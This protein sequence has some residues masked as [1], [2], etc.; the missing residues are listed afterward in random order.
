[1]SGNVGSARR[2]EYAAI[3]DT[4]NTAARLE[5]MTKGTPY[6][7]FVGRPDA[8]AAAPRRRTTSSRVDELEVRGR[9][10]AVKVW[11]L[12]PAATVPEEVHAASPTPPLREHR[13]RR[14]VRRSSPRRPT[15][16]P[17]EL[18]FLPEATASDWATIFSYAQVREVSA[19][20]ALVQAGEDDRALYLL[21]DGHARRADAA[22]GDRVQDDRRAVRARRAGVLRRRA[23]LGDARRA[24]RR[25]R[26]CASTWTASA[27]LGA[28]AGARRTRCCWTSRGS[29][30]C[31]CAW[32]ATSSSACAGE[33]PR[34]VVA[35][36]AALLVAAPA[37][38]RACRTAGSACRSTGR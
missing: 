6:Q 13:S 17:A 10:G 5:G 30:R 32:P 27:A 22:R 15:R 18:L 29:W 2:L 31:G 14:A 20:L 7:L 36:L 35:A 3:G 4:T 24:D 38:T 28:R 23:A 11:A 25:R 19:G 9:E 1:M 12:R 16:T 26:S 37:Q 21:I 33:A 8:R 34:V